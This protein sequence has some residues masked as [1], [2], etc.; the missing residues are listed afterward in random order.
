MPLSI[1]IHT[2]NPVA[3]ADG[4]SEREQIDDAL[5]AIGF[6][7]YSRVLCER[8]GVDPHA[9]VQPAPEPA[10]DYQAL[11]VKMAAEQRAGQ[12]QT[13]A[14][15]AQSAEI[16][17]VLNEPSVIAKR[18]RGK[19]SAGRKRRTA[20]EVAEDEA[21]DRVDTAAH[22][23]PDAP[24][25]RTDPENRIDPESA[26]TVAQD[27]A[28]ETAEVEAARD[29]VKPLTLEDVRQA[30]GEYVKRYGMPATQEDGAKIFVNILGAPPA[31]EPIWKMSILPDDQDVL[32]KAVDGWKAAIEG[33]PFGRAV[34]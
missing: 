34:L 5:G 11:A 2:E 6:V 24:Q 21:A 28:D 29:P 8:L 9:L 4:R 30:V 31:G 26:E 27:A 17:S 12:E 32:R 18:E 23:P 13:P 1:T 3:S 33:N 15:G 14:L 10:P 16:P 22:T 25:I 20:E 19:P 7:R